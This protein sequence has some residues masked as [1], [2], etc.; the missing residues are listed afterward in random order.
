MNGMVMTLLMIMISFQINT[1]GSSYEH[2]MLTFLLNDFSWNFYLDIS[3]SLFLCLQ[4]LSLCAALSIQ[5]LDRHYTNCQTPSTPVK[6]KT[7][8]EIQ[9]DHVNKYTST[10]EQRAISTMF[11]VRHLFRVGYCKTGDLLPKATNQRKI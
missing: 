9:V 1:F 8:F 4:L 2:L 10:G 11:Y 3:L 7:L 5:S 6:R